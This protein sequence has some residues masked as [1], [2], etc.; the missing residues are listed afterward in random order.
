MRAPL[1]PKITNSIVKETRH[2]NLPSS[3]SSRLSGEQGRARDIAQPVQMGWWCGGAVCSVCWEQEK[4]L[5]SRTPWEEEVATSGTYA[6]HV[7]AVG[8]RQLHRADF[9]TRF[10]GSYLDASGLGWEGHVSMVAVLPTMWL[11]PYTL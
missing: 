6:V 1:N 8:D 5:S 2:D 11:K 9:R 4:L 3:P 10:L 7:T